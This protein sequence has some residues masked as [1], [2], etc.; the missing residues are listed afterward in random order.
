MPT[1]TINIRTD[2]DALREIASWSLDRPI[3]QRDALRRLVVSGELTADDITEL[4]ALCKDSTKQNEP[5]ETKHIGI[6]NSGAPTVA[7]RNVRDV[8]NVNALAEGQTLNFIP[9]GV[10]IVYGDNGAG[11]SGYVRILKQ[12]CRARVTRGK[13]EQLL[14]NIYAPSSGPQVAQIEYNAGAQ[15]QKSQ[16]KNGEKSDDLLSEVSVFDS[17]TANVHVEETNDLAYTPYSMKL[18]ERLVNA[19]KAVKENLDAEI[20]TLKSQ[21]PEIIKSP[22]CSPDTKV[23]KLVDKL[24]KNTDPQTVH[25][26][27]TLS[28]DEG[29]RLVEL[30]ADFAQDP[31]A[32]ARRLRA[33]KVR[34]E[35]TRADIIALNEAIS[36]A[37][38]DELARLAADLKIKEA[39][40]LVASQNLSKDEP[41]DGVGSEVWRSLWEAARAYSTDV[42]YPEKEYPATDNNARCVLCQQELDADAAARLRRFENFVQDRTQQDASTARQALSSHRETLRDANILHTTLRDALTFIG[43]ELGNQTLSE[44]IREYVITARLLLRAMLRVNGNVTKPGQTCITQSLSDAIASLETRAAALLADDDSDERKAMRLE[45]AELQ[46][47]QW[48]SGIQEDVIA[49]IGRRKSIDVIETSLKDT[50]P[51]TITAKNTAL[52]EALITEKLRGTFAREIDRLNLSGL[53][54]EL[55]QAGSQA[56]VSRFRVSLMQSASHNAGDILSE[57]EYRCVALAGFM[58]ELATNNG[59]SGIIFD[60][61]VSSLDH[62]HREAIAKR[63]AEEGR[64]RQVVVFTHDLPFLFLLRNACAQVDDPS[65]KT[66]IALRH[67]QKRQNSPGHCRNEAPDKAQDAKTRLAQMRKH[68]TNTR[69]LYDRDPDSTDWLINARGLIDSLRQT[70]EAAVEDAISPVLRTFASKVN[71]KGFAKLSAITDADA[72][73]MRQHYGQCSELLHKA[74]DALNPKAPTPDVVEIEL[75]AMEK[76]SVAV[77]DRQAKIRTS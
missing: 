41:L 63:L 45:L 8:Q 32:T 50:R 56:G 40:A 25:D 68:L 19:C 58:A 72:N 65:L 74:S 2:H 21:T 30:A 73:T 55:T 54:I 6:Q 70:W 18:L 44:T 17:R 60:D 24:G 46:D 57:G 39:A 16:W 71:T 77:S 48:F 47:R 20:S 42:A 61:P 23:G 69:I 62:L 7:L 15:S 27:S 51:N 66:D 36:D 29:K 22:K 75:N 37:N 33:E 26:L 12:A 1:E 34:L 14:D 31:K 59:D 4:T 35:S 53:A 43:H 5:L 49:E 9:K 76:W 3:W 38:A 13:N 52:S 28:T 10:T 11:K 64:K 67:I